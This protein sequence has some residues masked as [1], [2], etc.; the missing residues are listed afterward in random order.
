MT[1]LENGD[2][3]AEVGHQTITRPL[4]LPEKFDG[5]GNF[6]EWISHFESIAALSKWNEEE[7]ILWV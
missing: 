2:P 1:T 3:P 6:K 7:K 4:V 5:T